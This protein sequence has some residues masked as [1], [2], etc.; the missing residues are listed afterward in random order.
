MMKAVH[1]EA[2]ADFRLRVRFADGTEGTVDLRRFAGR[3]VFLIWDEPG[4]FE[5]VRIGPSG[6][7]QW[8]EDV[9]LCPD[10]LY[11]EISR[12]AAEEI[13]PNLK[14]APLRA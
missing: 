1:V 2:L 8:S 11:L 12:K 5:R 6:E 7:A 4:A 3:G 13:F 10:A 9:A 14:E